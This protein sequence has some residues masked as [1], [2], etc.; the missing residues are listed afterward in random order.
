MRRDTLCVVAMGRDEHRK[1][2]TFVQ[3]YL[4]EGATRITLLDDRSVPPL[5][6]APAHQADPRAFKI[7]NH[8]LADYNKDYSLI[9]LY[10]IAQPT[11]KTKNL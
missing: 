11:H 9:Y 2:D 10:T 4:A 3:H 6:L 1:V 7:P 8:S 5:V